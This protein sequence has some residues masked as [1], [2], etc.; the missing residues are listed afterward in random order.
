MKFETIED[1]DNY[2]AELEEDLNDM[3]EYLKEHPEKLGTQGNY[4]TLQYLYS[5]YK[6]NKIKFIQDINEIKL[7]LDGNN[8]NPLSIENMYLLSSEFNNTKDSLMDLVK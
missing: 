3:E 8:M 1:Y 7:K 6:N 5:I 2:L 4:E